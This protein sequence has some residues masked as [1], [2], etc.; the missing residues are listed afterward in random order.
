MQASCWGDQVCD[1]HLDHYVCDH[2]SVHPVSLHEKFKM[3]AELFTMWAL[4]QR[5]LA[6]SAGYLETVTYF[7]SKCVV[8]EHI[9]THPRG[10]KAKTVNKESINQTVISSRMG[11]G[12]MGGV[13]TLSGTTTH[14]LFDTWLKNQ[15]SVTL[16]P[17]NPCKISTEVYTFG[18]QSQ[19]IAYQNGPYILVY[20]T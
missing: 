20:S 2:H 10:L 7:R 11:V 1:R 12:L 18:D 17:C 15:C 5:N 9:H 16:I 19:L 3:A 13:W 6:C 4:A 8:P 14:S